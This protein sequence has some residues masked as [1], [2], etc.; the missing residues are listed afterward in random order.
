MRQTRG[1][2]GSIDA[3]FSEEKATFL[4]KDLGAHGPPA[5][6]H[7]IIRALTRNEIAGMTVLDVGAGIG[8]L[9]EQLL[10]AGARSAVLVDI[11]AAYLEAAA[12][13]LKSAQITDRVQFRQGDVV[14][15]ASE[16]AD[17]DIVTLD[18]VICCY[19]DLA[20]LVNQSTSKAR[21]YYAASYPRYRW[22][23]RISIGFEN[24]MRRLR[25]NPFRAYVHPV[26]VIEGLIRQNG[27]ERCTVEQTFFW[28]CTMFERRADR[29]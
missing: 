1:C 16:L 18:K 23:T 17:A 7:L 28:R 25:G 4:S 11:S 22:A 14:E 21:R 2:C 19:P 27:F 9:A 29:P 24:F 20:P 5:E 15:L 3:H 13:R 12:R 6:T 10:A 8:V 26:T